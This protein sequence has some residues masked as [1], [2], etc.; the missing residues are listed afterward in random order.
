M[1]ELF[2]VLSSSKMPLWSKFKRSKDLEEHTQLRNN[3][4]YCKNTKNVSLWI[5]EVLEFNT[6]EIGDLNSRMT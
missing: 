5:T 4:R 1:I 2:T 3:K 6:I